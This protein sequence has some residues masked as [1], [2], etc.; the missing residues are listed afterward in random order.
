M[1]RRGWLDSTSNSREKLTPK[2][3]AKK[4]QTYLK[5]LEDIKNSFHTPSSKYAYKEKGAMGSWVN[6]VQGFLKDVG[7]KQEALNIRYEILLP[8]SGDIISDWWWKKGW[9]KEGITAIE[10]EEFLESALPKFQKLIEE[11]ENYEDDF[12]PPPKEQEEKADAFKGRIP[13]RK[14]KKVAQK[15]TPGNKIFIVHGH[16]KANLYELRDL[17]E[18]RYKLE[19]TIM[20]WKPG[21]GRTLIEKFEQEAQDSG[22]AF[23]IMTPDDLVKIPGK[24]KEYGQARPNVIFEVGWFYGRLGRNR[25]CILFKKGTKI[26]SDLDGI[27]RIEFNESV[28]EKVPEIEN[29]LRAAGLIK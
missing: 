11:I 12:L 18:K 13:A 8:N 16:D 5:E 21:K 25:V 17:L 10:A 26:H 9:K 1:M 6:R 19:C 29:E 27:S 24:E 7:L 3:I 22:F 15:I 14:A 2:E 20:M 4:L 28:T 23:I